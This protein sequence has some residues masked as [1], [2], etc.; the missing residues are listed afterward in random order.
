MEDPSSRTTRSRKLEPLLSTDSRIHLP[1]NHED[2]LTFFFPL[3]NNSNFTKKVFPALLLSFSQSR[4]RVNYKYCKTRSTILSRN[5]LSEKLKT[6]KGRVWICS[7]VKFILPWIH[8]LKAQDSDFLLAAHKKAMALIDLIGLDWP[9]WTG[10]LS[11]QTAKIYQ[12]QINLSLGERILLKLLP[13]W[14]RTYMF[15]H[16]ETFTPSID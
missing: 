3:H 2:V 9:W 15:F 11:D 7:S 10:Q 14:W 5:R 4:N 1:T 8:F 12:E 16:V 6:M 13:I